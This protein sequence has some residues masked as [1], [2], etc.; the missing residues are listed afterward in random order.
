M[1]RAAQV[2]SDILLGGGERDLVYHLENPIRQPWQDV[3]SVI[4]RHLS[5]PSLRRLSFTEWLGRV[6]AANESPPEVIGFLENHFLQVSTGGLILDTTRTRKISRAL[7]STNA[8]EIGTI[9]FYLDFW[10]SVGLLK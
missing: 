3:C 7:K 6:M 1:D 8:V 4:E 10:K 5:L 9:E 2:V